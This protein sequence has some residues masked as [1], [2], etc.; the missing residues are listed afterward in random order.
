MPAE[1]IA[2]AAPK[3][4]SS[5]RRCTSERPSRAR[6]SSTLPSSGSS[7]P[8]PSL[9]G[10]SVLHVRFLGLLLAASF[11]DERVDVALLDLHVQFERGAQLPDRRPPA[12]T[13]LRRLEGLEHLGHLAVVALEDRHRIVHR[14]LLQKC[15][16]G[17]CLRRCAR[18]NSQL[19]RRSA[20]CFACRPR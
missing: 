11:P 10:E 7:S 16:L 3:P 4:G 12:R 18:S 19:A 14:A 9:T 2:T 20:A 17:C 8:N 6:R 13:R 5:T 1:S 15:R